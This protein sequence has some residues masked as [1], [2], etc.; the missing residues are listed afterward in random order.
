[1]AP[2][3]NSRTPTLSSAIAAA[4]A[5]GAAAGAGDVPPA[6]PTTVE[7]AAQPKRSAKR[8][9]HD[10]PDGGSSARRRLPDAGEAAVGRATPR[11]GV[12]PAR[13][14]FEISAQVDFRQ[15]MLAKLGIAI[16]D[17]RW[18]PL[19]GMA[20]SSPADSRHNR[21]ISPDERDVILGVAENYLPLSAAH[22]SVIT[23]ILNRVLAPNPT[24]EIYYAYDYRVPNTLRSLYRALCDATP[25]GQGGYS[26]SQERAKAIRAR[27][28]ERGGAV[29]DSQQ[30]SDPMPSVDV[31][32]DQHETDQ[33][34]DAANVVDDEDRLASRASVAARGFEAITTESLRSVDAAQRGGL[35][36]L[37][38]DTAAGQL[39]QVVVAPKPSATR[40]RPRQQ[41]QEDSSKMDLMM[42]H[43]MERDAEDR[44]SWREHQLR[45]EAERQEQQQR[46]EAERQEQ[47]QRSEE[48][49]QR[50]ET[51]RQQQNQQFMLAIAAFA[52]QFAPNAASE[53]HSAGPK[54]DTE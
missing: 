44:R 4:E 15:E 47:Q 52:R 12:D 30:S 25:T 26:V 37:V 46:S 40:R 54:E 9:A 48:R 19:I 6:V 51:D 3:R 11:R 18:M 49:Q 14:A 38:D 29:E 23:D 36:S 42:I 17:G 34:N 20:R 33:L 22:W 50:V 24:Q 8:R 41:Q 53:P 28:T 10:E 35:S 2:K 27:V 45:V 39:P 1:M 16:D 32:A 7:G 5:E 13:Y 43:M 31:D 21:H